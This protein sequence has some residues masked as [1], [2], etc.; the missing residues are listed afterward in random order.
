MTTQTSVIKRI[1]ALERKLQP[2]DI[3]TVRLVTEN[4]RGELID[5]FTGEVVEDNPNDAVIRVGL[6]LSAI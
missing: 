3:I 1:D 6:D 2:R 4:E 5:Y